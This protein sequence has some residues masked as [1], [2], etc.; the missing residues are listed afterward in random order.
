MAHLVVRELHPDYLGLITEPDT[1]AKLTG[2]K[3]LNQPQKLVELFNLP[4]PDWTGV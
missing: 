3:E 4:C 1:Q 2:L